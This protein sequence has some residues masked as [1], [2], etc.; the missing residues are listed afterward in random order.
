M[1]YSLEVEDV[2]TPLQP[3]EDQIA[4][5]LQATPFNVGDQVVIPPKELRRSRVYQK[6]CGTG[7][8]FRKTKRE[9]HHSASTWH[10][11]I[12]KCHLTKLM[13]LDTELSPRDPRPT[14]GH[15]GPSVV[16]VGTSE[17]YSGEGRG[18]SCAVHPGPATAA[19]VSGIRRV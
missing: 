7:T 6:G 12:R 5:N 11:N 10:Q 3:Q 14:V 18:S 8:I 19:Q 9:C 2:P 4:M 13:K 1:Y 17:A 15:P 16:S